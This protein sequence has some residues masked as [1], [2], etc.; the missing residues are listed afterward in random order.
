MNRVASFVLCGAFLAACSAETQDAPAPVVAGGSEPVEV[1]NAIDW[2]A[3]RLALTQAADEGLGAGLA[4]VASS[5]PPA[6]VPVLLPSGLV[7]TASAEP[8]YRPL[9]DG[10]F[11]AYPGPRFDVIVNGTKQAFETGGDL[12]DARESML[13]TPS[14]AGAQ[15]SFSRFGADYLVEFECRVLDG[16]A[17]CITEEEALEISESL[18]VAAAQ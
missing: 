11:A 3:A 9:E 18:F 14:E 5:G 13:F 1:E 17:N 6:P 12:S 16:E 4:S 8:R 10:Y 2:G 15:V 7:R